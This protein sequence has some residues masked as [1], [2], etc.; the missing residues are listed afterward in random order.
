MWTRRGLFD[1]KDAI[2]LTLLATVVVLYST[3]KHLNRSAPSNFSSEQKAYDNSRHN[4]DSTLGAVTNIVGSSVEIIPNHQVYETQST[5]FDNLIKYTRTT[6]N[7]NASLLILVLTQD[8]SSW[9]HDIEKP[10]RTFHD[11]LDLLISTQLNLSTTSLALWTSSEEQYHLFRTATQRLDLARVSI[12]LDR[13]T[14][15]SDRNIR[16]SNEVG[17]Q[18]ARRAKVARL[19]NKLML[20]ALG[21]EPHLLWLD[22]D[23]QYLSPGIVQLMLSHSDTNPSAGIVT[24]RCTEGPTYNYDKNAWAASSTG[25]DLTIGAVPRHRHVDG[26][27]RGTKDS[28][29]IPLDSVGGTILYVRA[30]LVWEGLSF[31]SWNVAGTRWGRDGTDGIE[32]EGLCYAAR[33]MEGG[34][35]FVLGGGNYVGHT[36]L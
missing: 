17:V 34:G 30:R 4:F 33:S 31:P 27:I 15:S 32:T 11:F 2:I 6:P 24:A 10:P 14:D 28:D 35:C 12:V 3:L 23:V 18:N 13:N 26:L 16:H 1:L 36:N 22:A 20:H 19:R 9:G 7:A 21:P 25:S 29:L 5:Q 8:A